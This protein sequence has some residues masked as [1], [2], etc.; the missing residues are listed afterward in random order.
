MTAHKSIKQ[1][2]TEAVLAEIP[3]SHRIYHEL[4]ID[5]VVFKWW[6]TGRQDG[7]RLTDEGVTAFELAEIEFYDYEFTAEGKSHHSFMLELNKK[8][9]C[10]YYLGVNKKDKTKKLYIRLYDSKVAM[11]LGLY[12]TLE[13][14]LQSIKVKK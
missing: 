3:K 1:K 4:P 8:I 14:Y 2:I 12:G 6:F 10:P 9:K 13:E 11:M 7:L 5:D